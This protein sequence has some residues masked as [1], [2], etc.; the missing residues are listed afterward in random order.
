V[1]FLGSKAPPHGGIG[2]AAARETLQITQ[3]ND[4]IL[5]TGATAVIGYGVV[6][7]L[8]ILLVN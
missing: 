6:Q 3:N 4:E 7:N 5:H 2:W 8:L 1:C